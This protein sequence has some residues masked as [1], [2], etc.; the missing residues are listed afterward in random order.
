MDQ[1]KEIVYTFP[2][3]FFLFEF[4]F[5]MYFNDVFPSL[6]SFTD[7]IFAI[8]LLLWTVK[9]AIFYKRKCF[10]KEFILFICIS[11]FYF[12]YS[13]YIHSNVFPA[14]CG[15]F[16]IQIKP[17]IG[18]FMFGYIALRF[19]EKQ[20]TI[21]KRAC[22]FLFLTTVAFAIAAI[23]SGRIVDTLGI[24]FGHSTRYGTSLVLIGLTYL[25]CGELNNKRDLG[26]FLLIL[27]FSLLAVR[28]KIYG[29]YGAA[30]FLVFVLRGNVEIKL[31]IKNMISILLLF[32]LAIYAAWDKILFYFVDIDIDN[33]H[34]LVRPALYITSWQMLF[35]YFPFGSG[36]ASF[37]THYSGVYYS[38]IYEKYD[39]NLMWGLL[40]EEPM[41]VTDTQYPSIA[42]FG[43]FGLVLCCF[44]WARII[45]KA[46]R[47]KKY[48]ECNKKNYLIVV[49]ILLFLAIESVGDAVFTSNRGFYAMILLSLAFSNST[50]LDRE[51][52]HKYISNESIANK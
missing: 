25:L 42:Q 6:F 39:L 48:N 52:D 20:K 30:I 45:L 15:D 49:L 40:E 32:L 31:S 18:Y 36:L 26:M 28:A 35:D 4:I 22:L 37:A 44:F 11:I 14:I 38:D 51:K 3:C 23:I 9:Y 16:L 46:N 24:I 50:L 21:L 10:D 29:F 19:N 13:I 1:K 5:G 2:F 27:T 34:S 12:L 41:F 43:V 17:Y 47:I 33:E 7:E 8:L